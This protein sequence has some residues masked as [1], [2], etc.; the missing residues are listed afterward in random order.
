VPLTPLPAPKPAN[1]YSVPPFSNVGWLTA[2]SKSPDVLQIFIDARAS[3]N[4]QSDKDAALSS[5][6]SS[7]KVVAA[8]AL[9]AYGA[10]P[11]VDLSSLLVSTSAAGFRFQG[12]NSGSILLNA[13][14]SGNP[15]MVRE[16]LKYH[17]NLEARDHEGNTALFAAGDYLSTDADGARVECVRL[18]VHAGANV[19]AR[20]NDGN[21]PLHESFQ[22][23][24][25]EELL[26]LGANVNARN[27]DCETPIFTTVDSDAI[28]LFL[29]YGADL[30]LRNKKGQTVFEATANKGPVWQAAL[31]AATQQQASH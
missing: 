26:K 18:L 22:T 15:D 6:A 28:P 20:D 30:T 29:K 31:R 7:G 23:D 25:E 10:N 19:N 17:P 9:I 27:N 8:R 16:I 11:N 13:A 24:V 4:D 21:T 5:S 12:P 3:A 1:S 2:A 14:S